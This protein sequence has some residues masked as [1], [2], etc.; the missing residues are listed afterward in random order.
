MARYWEEMNYPQPTEEELQYLWYLVESYGITSMPSDMH[1]VQTG[2]V[3]VSVDP[4]TEYKITV[5]ANGR[6]YTVRGD[7]V[8]GMW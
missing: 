6:T 1:A 5:R 3:H 4:N 2:D 7:T 8:T